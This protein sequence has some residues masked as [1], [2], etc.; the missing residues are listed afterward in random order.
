MKVKTLIKRLQKLN[1]EA[2]IWYEYDSSLLNFN[3]FSIRKTF[4]DGRGNRYKSGD[5]EVY[6]VYR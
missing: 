4:K 5:K 3:Q 6:L 1:P 2:T